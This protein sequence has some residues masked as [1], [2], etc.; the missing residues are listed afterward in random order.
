MLMEKNHGN[1]ELRKALQK[2]INCELSYMGRFTKEF[3]D[4]ICFGF[5]EI[6]SD[7]LNIG[8]TSCRYKVYFYTDW[9]INDSQLTNLFG[10]EDLYSDNNDERISIVRELLIHSKVVDYEIGDYG[11]LHILLGNGYSID[12]FNTKSQMIE[13]KIYSIVSSKDNKQYEIMNTRFFE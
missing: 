13:Q 10:I 7:Q 9:R 5:E 4:V 1:T 12:V 8:S 6:S 2:I 3:D 11:D